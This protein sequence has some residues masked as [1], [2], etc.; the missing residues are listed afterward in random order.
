MVEANVRRLVPA[1]KVGEVVF[2]LSRRAPFANQ[3]SFI[4]GQVLLA[5]VLDALRWS[6]GSALPDR[7]EAGL[8]PFLRAGAPGDGLPLGTGQHVLGATDRTSGMER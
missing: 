8:E 2:F 1:G 5:F 3:S 4:A 6:I 7:G